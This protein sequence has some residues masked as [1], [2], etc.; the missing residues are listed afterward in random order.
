M[1]TVL[2]LAVAV[3]AACFFGL[4]VSFLMTRASNFSA[5]ANLVFGGLAVLV[6]A[7]ILYL[8]VILAERWAFG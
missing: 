2:T 8:A 1:T 4:I 6:L 7:G 5:A 3:A